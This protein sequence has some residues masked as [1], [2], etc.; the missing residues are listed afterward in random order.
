MPIRDD[1]PSSFPEAR[2]L[3]PLS[4]DQA[5]APWAGRRMYASAAP[6]AKGSPVDETETGVEFK[7]AENAMWSA[8]LNRI[9][10]TPMV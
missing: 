1:T 8:F 9:I 6:G 2:S 3:P 7:V 4:G 5:V 10:K